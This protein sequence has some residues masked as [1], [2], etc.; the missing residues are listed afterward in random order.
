[1]GRWIGGE[2]YTDAQ[3]KYIESFTPRGADERIKFHETVDRIEKDVRDLIQYFVKHKEHTQNWLGCVAG[4]GIGVI[5][6]ALCWY[7][8]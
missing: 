7:F 3:L 6:L 8:K 2:W 1:M 4:I 5:V